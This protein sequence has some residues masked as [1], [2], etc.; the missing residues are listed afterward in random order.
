MVGEGGRTNRAPL[1]GD[2]PSKLSVV[3]GSLKGMRRFAQ[4]DVFTASPGLGNPVAVVLDAEG[5]DDEAMALLARWTNLS[6]TTFVLPPS[7]DAADYRVRIFTPST[8]LPFAGHPTIGTCQALIDAGVLS[9]P[10]TGG[11]EWVQ[12]CAAGLITIRRADDG[13]LSFAAPSAK[14]SGSPMTDVLLERILGVTP[15][16]PLVVDVGPRWLTGRISLAELDGLVLDAPTFLQTLDEKAVIGI[17]LYAVDDERQVHVRSFFDADNALTEDPVCGSG[18][19][20]V[21]VH[22][23][24][25]GRT[26]DVPSVYQARQGSHRGR[27]GRITVSLGDTIWVGGHAVTV[28]SG[29]IAV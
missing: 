17:N 18:N 14:V 26:A 28:I 5:L 20:A 24:E 6:E 23:I 21:G 22:L 8:E 12:E 7:S 19:V 4:V 16:D 25:T 11:A 1:P 13:T 3:D 15:S 9:G 27:D 2:W 29:T 10:A